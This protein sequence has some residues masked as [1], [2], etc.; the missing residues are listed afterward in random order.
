MEH[1]F[2]HFGENK[3]IYSWQKRI[4]IVDVSGVNIEIRKKSL[5]YNLCIINYIVLD[6]LPTGVF[7]V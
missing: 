3:N 5:L 6:G 7:V 4:I 2:F 1:L